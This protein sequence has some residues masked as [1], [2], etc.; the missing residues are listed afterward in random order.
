MGSDVRYLGQDDADLEPGAKVGEY[1][2]ERKIGEGGFGAVFKAE[3]PVIGKKVAIK[4]L[5]RQYSAQP[6]MVSRFVAEARAVNQIRHRNIIDIFS[7]GQLEDGRHYYVMEHLDGEPLDQVMAASGRLP[8]P[9]TIQVLRALARALDAAHA[10]GIVHRDL[11]PENIFYVQ[12]ADGT[13]FPKLLDF[14]IAKLLGDQTPQSYKTRTGAPMG[15]PAYMSPEQCRGRDVDHR[16]DIY[17]FGVLAFEMLTG[18]I[19]FL[20]EDYMDILLKQIGEEPPAPSS[21]VPGLPAAVDQGVLWM[22]RKDPAERP[23]N[24]ITAVRA[25]EEAARDAGIDL[26]VGPQPSGGYTSPTSPPMSTQP[27]PGSLLRT[28]TP[29]RPGRGA[30]SIGTEDTLDSSTLDPVSLGAALEGMPASARRRGRGVAVVA[31]GLVVAGAAVAMVVVGGGG[32]DS[33][34]KSAGGGAGAG[35]SGLADAAPAVVVRP[36][37]APALPAVVTITIDGPPAGTDV[38]GSHGLVGV[39]PGKVQLAR[40]ETEIILTLKRDG[41]ETSTVIVVPRTDT[42]VQVALAKKRDGKGKG[43]G[44]GKGGRDT[45]E[46]PFQ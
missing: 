36:D 40:G 30:A 29:P 37:A 10:K 14:G 19:P 26:P 31:A 43:S 16:T 7:F 28:P 9:V 46:D 24:L 41:Y 12:E 45:L 18:R 2:V 38:Y 42:T 17:A 35:V 11:K 4:V 13:S 5:A 44:K 39:A 34:G 20:G 15:T 8:L 25:L 22:L 23:P 32:G 3:H 27:T 33:G 6:E 21:I 1:V